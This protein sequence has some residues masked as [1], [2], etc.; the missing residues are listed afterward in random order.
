MQ[1]ADKYLNK[2]EI[3]SISIEINENFSEQKKNI[4]EIMKKNNFEFI[5]KKHSD[6]YSVGNFSKSFNY[7][8]ERKI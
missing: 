8:F 5:Q 7:I 4:L 1:G 2:E 3:K 6:I